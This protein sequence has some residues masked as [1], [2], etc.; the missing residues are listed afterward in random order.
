MI[1][2]FKPSDY[3]MIASWWTSYN[4]PAPV[5][6]SMISDGTFIMEIN[7]TPALCLTT[8]LTQSKEVAYIA[9][10]VKN[11]KFKDINLEPEGKLLWDHCFKFAKDKG[12]KRVICFSVVSKLADKYERFGMRKTYNNLNSFVKEL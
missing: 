12:Y 3:E 11:P 1:K 10:F 7:K 9:G 8:F 5:Q 2:Q 6:G 4:E